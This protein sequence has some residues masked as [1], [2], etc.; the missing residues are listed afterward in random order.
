MRIII[1][2]LFFVSFTLCN[3]QAQWH[4]VSQS[5]GKCID[6]ADGTITY[7]I[8]GAT[9]PFTGVITN[10]A[11]CVVANS[12]VTSNGSTITFTGIPGCTSFYYF[13]FYNQSNTLITNT[14]NSFGVYSSNPLTISVSSMTA[15]TCASCCD[16][17]ANL[18]Y[19][20]GSSQNPIMF[21]IDG[22]YQAGNIWP[23]FNI[24]PGQHI[25][26]GKDN[27]GCQKCITFVMP[28][29][30][31]GLDK[32][33][34]QNSRSS[35]FPNPVTSVFTISNQKAFKSGEQ[36]VIITLL[37]EIVYR[38]N[39]NS[40]VTS[41]KIDMSGIKSGFYILQVI[42]NEGVVGD[43]SLLIKQ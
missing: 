21:Y 11:G 6:V 13:N 23:A 39:I 15:A 8:S 24:C 4:W 34:V 20:G 35:V 9:P 2:V 5:G 26:C 31:S 28:G 16:G 29:G 38:E 7:S 14:Q 30:A 42:G 40:E 1:T 3:S 36:V 10:T 25:L 41:L 22:V 17:L 12:T 32:G 43:K 37:G 33:D 19:S 18:S 27:V